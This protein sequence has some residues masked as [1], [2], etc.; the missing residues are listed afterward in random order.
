MV[1]DR[2]SYTEM[3]LPEFKYPSKWT[4]DWSSYIKYRGEIVNKIRDYMEN[5]D[6]YL[7]SLKKQTDKL[8]KDF[9]SGKNLYKVISNER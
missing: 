7:V 6:N 8:S 4:E 2:L 1:P 5:Y 9:F 3:A